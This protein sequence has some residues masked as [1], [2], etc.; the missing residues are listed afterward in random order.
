M[1]RRRYGNLRDHGRW[2]QVDWP[3][4]RPRG[5]TDPDRS[6]RGNQFAGLTRTQENLAVEVRRAGVNDAARIAE[7]HVL[8][9]Q[10]G[11]RGLLP[12]DYLDGMQ[13]SGERLERWTRELVSLDWSR[14]GVL[15]AECDDGQLAGFARFGATRDEDGDPAGVGE[16]YSIYVAPVAWGQGLGRAVMSAA[17]EHL[18]A[19]DYGE[20]TL[21]VLDSNVR[22]RRFYAAAG[23]STDGR[24]KTDETYGFPIREVRYRRSLR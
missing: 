15:V 12:Q 6:P 17:L 19:A 9:W 16:V 8:G 10:G 22:A 4:A 1:F 20:A 3:A 14:G 7:I 11:Y 18:A 2:Q 5:I 24:E 23:F 21:W 13:A